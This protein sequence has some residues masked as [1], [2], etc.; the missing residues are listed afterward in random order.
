[1]VHSQDGAAEGLGLGPGFVAHLPWDPGK[2]LSLAVSQFPHL[3]D[4]RVRLS[5]SNRPPGRQREKQ[6][7]DGMPTE[8]HRVPVPDTR[9]WVA[10]VGLWALPS[11]AGFAPGCFSL[12]GA[13]DSLPLRIRVGKVAVRKLHFKSTHRQMMCVLGLLWL[14]D[15]GFLERCGTPA[16]SYLGGG[17]PAFTCA[18][19][20]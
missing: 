4:E 5:G 9:G 15:D 8:S 1:M 14:I 3:Q 6:C 7:K 11:T 10:A 13:G 2:P 16:L 18:P 17:V 12:A 20:S 19:L